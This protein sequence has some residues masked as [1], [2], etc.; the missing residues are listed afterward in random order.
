[1]DQRII[2]LVLFSKELYETT[3][4]KVNIAFGAVLRIWHDHRAA[5]TED[6]EKATLPDLEQLQEASCIRISI[7]SS[8][9]KKLYGVF[10]RS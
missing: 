9:I 6:P 1:V 10:D 2:D 3:G 4:G 8:L 5:G 7:K